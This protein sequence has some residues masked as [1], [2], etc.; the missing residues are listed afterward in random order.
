MRDYHS[1][2]NETRDIYILLYL[3]RLG[4]HT[5]FVTQD[6]QTY[7]VNPIVINS[8]K[9]FPKRVKN[10]QGLRKT[11]LFDVEKQPRFAKNFFGWRWKT[12]KV[13]EKL[14]WLTLKNSQ[15]LR[16]TFLVDVE[17]QSRFAKNFFVWRW[18][19]AKVYKKLFWL[20]L[21]NCQGLQKTFLVDIEKLPRF[22][23]NFFG[24]RSKT[25]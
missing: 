15:G 5:Y 7:A 11:F 3:S 14:F 6:K 21:K 2:C 13:C 25:K 20:T 24:W 17:K 4:R 16:K 12:A 19:T 23:K 1:K 22:A 10:S 18:K 8:R 9:I